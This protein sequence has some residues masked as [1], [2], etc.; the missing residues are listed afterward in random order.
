MNFLKIPS[1]LV[2]EGQGE[3]EQRNGNQKSKKVD[4][5]ESFQKFPSPSLGRVGSGLMGNTII[6]EGIS[7]FSTLLTIVSPPLGGRKH[8]LY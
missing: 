4:R 7:N 3:G 8:L 6:L 1:P 2:G 5:R